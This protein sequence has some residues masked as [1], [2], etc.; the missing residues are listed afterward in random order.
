MI[1]PPIEDIG[2]GQ[3]RGGLK[4]AA[5]KAPGFGDRRKAMLQDIAILTGGEA[6][7]EDLGIKLENV[8]LILDRVARSS[9]SA[10]PSIV[11]QSVRKV[12]AGCTAALRGSLLRR[13]QGSTGDH[14]TGTGLCR[15]IRRCF[16][17]CRRR[18]FNSSTLRA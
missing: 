16:I 7:S 2:G 14:K 4:V 1:R 17:V 10:G 8:T 5:V 15:S 18:N 11:L 12:F 13:R 9:Q 6:I 3:L